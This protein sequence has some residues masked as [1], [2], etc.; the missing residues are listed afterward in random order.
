MATWKKILTEG[1]VVPGDLAS[2]A[3]A[4]EILKV[5]S[6]GTALEWGSST[7]TVTSVTANAGT[8]SGIGIT[9]TGGST[10]EIAL[11]GGV[12]KATIK[13]LLSSMTQGIP[14]S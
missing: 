14:Y 7:G 8:V 9:S 2:G 4:G 10:P 11:T 1:N 6:G 13:T 5:A 12:D 3:D